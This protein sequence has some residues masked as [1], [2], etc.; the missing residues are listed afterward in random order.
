MGR[1]SKVSWM[2]LCE[3]QDYNYETAVW[4]KPFCNCSKR[5]KEVIKKG[6]KTDPNRCDFLG[7]EPDCSFFEPVDS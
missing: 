7:H 6:I 5:N 1:I 4:E 2:V 3:Y